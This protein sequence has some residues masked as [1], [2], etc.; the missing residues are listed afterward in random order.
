MQLGL[1]DQVASYLHLGTLWTPEGCFFRQ[2]ASQQHPLWGPARPEPAREPKLDRPVP[3]PTPRPSTASLAAQR[4]GSHPSRA[5]HSDEEAK[6][7][8]D[9]KLCGSQMRRLRGD[10][11]RLEG[12]GALTRTP[13]PLP[14]SLSRSWVGQRARAWLPGGTDV[15]VRAQG[16]SGT[17]E[18]GRE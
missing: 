4:L 14:R 12:S 5:E 9:T 18:G 17:P 16:H 3:P 10:H 1:W 11:A 8:R 7:L 6:G 15:Q 13:A 2:Q